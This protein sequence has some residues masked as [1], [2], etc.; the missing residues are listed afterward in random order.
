MVVSHPSKTPGACADSVSVFS[1]DTSLRFVSLTPLLS[2]ICSAKP[3]TSTL[4]TPQHP[5]VQPTKL[6]HEHNP[7]YSTQ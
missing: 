1:T 3:P 6:E 2:I 5:V 4:S 7:L